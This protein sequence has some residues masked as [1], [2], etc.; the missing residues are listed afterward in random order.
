MKLQ[1]VADARGVPLDV[2]MHEM[3]AEKTHNDHGE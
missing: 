1:K 2:V 3:V